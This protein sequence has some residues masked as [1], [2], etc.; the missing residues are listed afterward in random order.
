MSDVPVFWLQYTSVLG[1]FLA[2]CLSGLSL[3]LR[4]RDKR[5]RLQLTQLMSALPPGFTPPLI[6]LHMA[7]TGEKPTHIIAAALRLDAK[8]SMFLDLS[9]GE[10]VRRNPI[11]CVLEPGTSDFL[12]LELPTLAKDLKAM[13]FYPVAR[14]VFEVTDDTHKT[15]KQGIEI[16]IKDCGDW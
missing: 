15:Y 1:A 16:D 5:P 8:S 3:Y 12:L 6:Q 2:L 10:L 7:N 13:G 11:P 4:R 14:P 9:A